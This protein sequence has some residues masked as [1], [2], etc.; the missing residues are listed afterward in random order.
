[1]DASNIKRIDRMTLTLPSD[2]EIVLTRVFEAPRSLVFEA[3]TKPEHMMHWYGCWAATLATCAIDLRVGGA[4]RFAMRMSDGAMHTLQGVYREVVPP[5]RLVY[6]E[7]YVG[8]SFTSNEALV[9]VTFAEKDG[10]TT[11]TGRTLHASRADRDAHLNA[12]M[13][14]GAA[15][16]LDRLAEYLPTL[17][18][19]VVPRSA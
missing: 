5:A 17:N 18:L 8:E 9:T 1:M 14:S 15:Q 2:R 3:W 10:R 4:Y 7:T 13:E 6:T 12:G 19:Q 11:F 16:T